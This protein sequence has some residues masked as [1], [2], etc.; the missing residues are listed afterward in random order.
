MILK[1]N[2]LLPSPALNWHH[3]VL[4]SQAPT[5]LLLPSKMSGCQQVNWAMAG[6]LPL[7]NVNA[8]KEK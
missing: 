7:P 5:F 8:G 1:E 3:I 6:T 4:V 2:S